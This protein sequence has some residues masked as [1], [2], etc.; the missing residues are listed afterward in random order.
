MNLVWPRKYK[1]KA[2]IVAEHLADLQETAAAIAA[3][4]A[5]SA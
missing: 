1:L 3:A 5:E 4:A 2:Q